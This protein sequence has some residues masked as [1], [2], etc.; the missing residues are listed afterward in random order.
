MSC[1]AALILLESPSH[2]VSSVSSVLKTLTRFPI[3]SVASSDFKT[4]S[5]RSKSTDG[6][7]L[8]LW[9]DCFSEMFTDEEFYQVDCRL[10][11]ACL[12]LTSLEPK[13][14]VKKF[15]LNRLVEFSIKWVGG[16]P[17]VH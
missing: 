9:F 14:R 2:S 7:R 1:S 15:L 5:A 11:Q 8:H 17:L 10:G 16:V 6:R 13:G 4:F 12:L 3:L